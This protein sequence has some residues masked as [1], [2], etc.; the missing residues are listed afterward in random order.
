VKGGACVAKR[1]NVVGA[2]ICLILLIGANISG[3]SK[4]Q[5]ATEEIPAVRAQIVEENSYGINSNYSGEVRGRY[6]SQLAFQVNGKI[7]K[8]NV[9]LG[10]VVN[11][12]DVLMQIEPKDI[13]QTMNINS[14]QVNSAE[15]QV[16]LAGS[17]LQ[18]YKQLYE[19]NAISRAQYDQ[20]QTAYDTA[21]ADRSKALAQY[22]QSANQMDYSSLYADSPGVIS[23]INAEI[24]QVV[25]AGQSIITLVKD[26]ALEV[27]ISIPEN[28]IEEVR[29]VQQVS[30]TFWAQPNVVV[31]GKVREISPMADKI[32]R[33]YK[34]RISLPDV[35]QSIKLGMTAN[36]TITGPNSQKALY[37][38]VTAIYQTQDQPYI[39]VVNNDIVNLNP[40]T[41]GTIGDGKVQVIEGLQAGA[42]IVTAGV[43]KLREGQRVRIAGDVL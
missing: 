21:V 7:I 22:A 4:T 25:S 39:W 17:N 8:R 6:E 31:D 1:R 42:V 11:P 10:S 19:Q 37:I 40:I 5:P 43:H 20:Y 33:T 9:D 3:C 30:V 23:S 16:A 15:S 12:G 41:I 36:V 35:P 18:R 13:Q 32:S 34:V 26:G 14:A 24:N 28:R 27:E 29:N 2:Y 38:P